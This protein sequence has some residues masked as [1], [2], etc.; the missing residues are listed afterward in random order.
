MKGI[1]QPSTWQQ[2]KAPLSLLPQ[3]EVC[4]LYRHCKSPK[5]EVTGEGRRKVLIIAEAP[6]EN[7]DRLGKQLVGNAGAEL[8][9]ILLGLGVHLRRDCWLTNAVICRPMNEDLDNR[10]P[11]E[12]EIS[13]C[14]PNLSKTLLSLQPDVIIPLGGPALK[15]LIPLAWK[16]GEV[17]EV[18]R[19]VG[20]RIPSIK[21]NSWIAPTYHPSF[22]LHAKDPA[23]E[24]HVTQHLKEAFELEGK[25]HPRGRPDYSS[26]CN[27]EFDHHK[28]AAG[29]RV[30]M[31]SGRALAVDI[32]SSVLK[33]DS[34][35]A[36]ILCCSVSDGKI[37]ISYPWYGEA[38]DATRELILSDIPKI[39]ANISFE[40][41]WFRKMFGRG[42]KNWVWDTVLASHWMDCRGGI[43]S[44]KFQLFVKLGWEDYNSHLDKYMV[45]DNSNTPNRL[46]EVEPAVLL[47]YCALDSLGEAL[48]AHV[49]AKEM[50]V[51]LC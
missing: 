44:V 51:S 3:C 2:M 24:L 48:L 35:H 41:K 47:R 26:Q 33:A 25:P 23:A 42:V 38:I 1:F 49:Q 29:V 11:T 43:T 30:L 39:G 20:W 4:Q 37:S 8:S 22:L 34:P 32:E 31:S 21:L 19:W 17:D 12:K 13:A 10:T 15:S 46:K 28:A 14:R 6:G 5:M 16:E 50:G 7:E 27:V 36:E 45:S 9:R 40:E 18:T